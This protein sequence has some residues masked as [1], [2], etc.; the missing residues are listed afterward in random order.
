MSLEILCEIA[1]I[2]TACK[3]KKNTSSLFF[4]ARFFSKLDA[5][6]DGVRVCVCREVMRHQMA[7]KVRLIDIYW[8]LY[9][10]KRVHFVRLKTDNK[11]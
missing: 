8:H 6:G 11:I 9:G 2:R 5:G 1:S 3:M 4:I 7:N 10:L